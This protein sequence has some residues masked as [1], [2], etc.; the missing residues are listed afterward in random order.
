MPLFNQFEVL[1][2]DEA[3][4]FGL[5]FSSNSTFDSSG[6]SL[7][8]FPLRIESVLCDM[9]ITLS[10]VS[11]RISELHSHKAYG[12]ND[13]SAMVLK[14]CAQELVPVLS[15]LYNKYLAF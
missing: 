10:M 4:Y 13:I 15:E 5:K 7:P 8:D 12:L 14:K 6:V 9:H 1:S 3:N 2:A 11:A